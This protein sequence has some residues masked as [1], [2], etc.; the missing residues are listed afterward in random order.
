MQLRRR[1]GDRRSPWRS[2]RAWS[3]WSSRTKLGLGHA[4]GVLRH[5]HRG[6]HGHHR[7]SRR[8]ADLRHRLNAWRA[9]AGL[10]YASKY[11]TSQQPAARHLDPARPQGLRG[12]G[13][14]RDRQHPRRH[15]GGHDSSACSSSFGRRLLLAHSAPTSTSSRSSS[16]VLLFRPH[17][18]PGQGDR[19]E[20]VSEPA[21]LRLASAARLPLVHRPR[22]AERSSSAFLAGA[23]H[24]AVSRQGAAPTS[25]STS[26][27]PSRSTMVNGFTGQFSMGHAGFMA[28]GRLRRRRSSPT[29]VVPDLGKRGRADAASSAPGRS[30]FLVACLRGRSGGGGF[31][32]LVG[33]PL[34]APRAA[35]TWPSSPSG[36]AEIVRVLFQQHGRG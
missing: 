28:A 12:R 16:L 3:G 5:A 30:L 17:R 32:W 25:G 9:A 18:H 11:A 29:T 15:A 34:A 2:W 19:G 13:G 23:A 22:L 6:A 27:L 35:T 24:E 31:G 21:V 10:L 8:L 7:G 1:P 20:G 36:F 14:R 4:R 26:S 33:L